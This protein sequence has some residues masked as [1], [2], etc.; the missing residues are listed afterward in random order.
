MKEPRAVTSI[1]VARRAGVSQSAVSR[2]FTPGAAV[3]ALTREKVIR[4]AHE[5]AYRPNAI[6][7][8]LSTRRSR[9]VGLVLSS[10][11]NQLY[12]LV[13][14]QLSRELQTH[15]LHVMLF[16][17]DGRGVDSALTELLAYQ[18]DGV[19]IAS[20]TVSSKLAEECSR[21]GIPV[22]MFNRSADHSANATSDNASSVTSDNCEAGRMAAR[23]LIAGGHQRIAYIAGRE[24]S[25]TNRD[26]ERGIVETLRDAGMTLHRRVLGNYDR[27]DA[28]EAARA[29]VSVGDPPDAVIVASDHM[30]LAVMDT[31]RFE[32]A[33]R[34]PEDMSVVGFDDVPAS[35][36]PSY[37]LT[38]VAQS[39]GSMVRSTLSVLLDQMEPSSER[40]R[41]DV[42]VGCRL[43]VRTSARLALQATA[44]EQRVMGGER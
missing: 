26:R 23:F 5:L 22:V 20:A 9:I 31:L 2:A 34:I 7:R 40:V 19:V 32:C 38:T 13:T 30:A 10:L 21:A 36:W 44:I 41:R 17:S 15:G 8:T 39:V 3:S 11:D 24:D 1:D 35:S 12:P 42:V 37:Q 29:L 27:A 33:V 14:E 43:V 25:S 18:L 28:A 4:A 6:A 16:F